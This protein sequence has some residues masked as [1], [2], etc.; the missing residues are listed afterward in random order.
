MNEKTVN[1]INRKEVSKDV[2]K[3]LNFF[4]N[5]VNEILVGFDDC[6]CDQIAGI[7]KEEIIEVKLMH[8]VKLR[9]EVLPEKEMQIAAQG[10]NCIIPER[11]K[12]TAHVSNAFKNKMNAAYRNK[13]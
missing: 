8:G 3:Q 6:I 12:I 13:G 1:K 7:G 11:L 4:A 5:A 2:A 10:R 9:I